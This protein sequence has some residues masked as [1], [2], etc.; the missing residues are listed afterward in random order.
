MFRQCQSLQLK[1][2]STQLFTEIFPNQR[3]LIILYFYQLI[4]IIL[5]ILI[6]EG[7][8]PYFAVIFCV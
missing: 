8:Q 2:I 7:S 5:N 4:C 3:Q 6:E 1:E